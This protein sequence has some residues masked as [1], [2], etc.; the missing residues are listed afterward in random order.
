M[1]AEIIVSEMRL[2]GNSKSLSVPGKKGSQEDS[3]LLETNEASKYRAMVARGNYLG[4]DRSDIQFAVKELSRGM[5]NPTKG[6]WSALK[7]LARY[8]SNK[9]RI[10]T[11]YEYQE[12]TTRIT[13]YS[14]SDFAGCASTRKSTSGG[15]ILY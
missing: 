3:E 8:L 9:T 12:E 11:K 1:H 4:Q 6:G 10:V 5:S 14:D 2:D 13:A 7:R 15:L